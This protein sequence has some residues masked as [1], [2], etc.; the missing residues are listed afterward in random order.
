MKEKR[1]LTEKEKDSIH[2]CL[3]R[4][5][6]NK[7]IMIGMP[8]LFIL[9]FLFNIPFYTSYLLVVLF[10]FVVIILFSTIFSSFWK[11]SNKYKFLE[12]KYTEKEIEN[13]LDNMS[14]KDFLWFWWTVLMSI[15]FVVWIGCI[16]TITEI[17][18]EC[19]IWKTQAIK[20][21]R[22]PD[23]ETEMVRKQCKIKKETL[24]VTRLINELADK[25]QQSICKYSD[26]A[27]E[28][29]NTFLRQPKEKQKIM[30]EPIKNVI[31][32][33]IN[34]CK[35]DIIA[36]KVETMDSNF[37]GDFSS[38]LNNLSKFQERINNI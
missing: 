27:L 18:E 4:L 12:E 1:F 3:S 11:N 36:K 7:C 10:I 33:E 2:L 28:D 35:E 6:G 24:G 32:K 38:E 31:S 8:I 17:Q 29:I 19:W 15:G 37:E 23:E 5:N 25:N 21:M 34:R 30:L 9:I 13:K 14:L 22:L 20:I 16:S 26:T